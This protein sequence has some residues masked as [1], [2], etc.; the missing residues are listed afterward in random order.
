MRALLSVYDKTGIVEFAR[1]LHD[2]DVELV[3]SGGT[4]AKIAEAGIPVTDVAEF[5][6]YP[7]MLGHRVVTLHP[8]VHG[9]ILADPNDE[10]HQADIEQYGIQPFDLV[11]VN[12]YPFSSNPSVDMIDIGGPTMVRGA[13]KNFARVTVVVDPA[14]YNTIVV[15]VGIGQNNDK[16]L[17]SIGWRRSMARRAFAHTASYEAAIVQWFD[18]LDAAAERAAGEE[19]ELPESLHL[20]ATASELPLRYG[21]NPHQPGGLYLQPGSCWETLKIHGG[22]EMSYLNVYDANAA[23]RLVHSFC[24]GQPAIH[25]HLPT[26]VIVKHANPCGV[27]TGKDVREAYLR[28][29]A[30]DRESAFGG[31]VA[32]SKQVDV[33]TAREIVKIFTEVVVAPSYTK[34]AVAVLREKQ[35]LRILQMECPAGNELE[36]RMVDRGFLVQPPDRITQRE[37]H[38]RVVTDREPSLDEELDMEFA[39]R[40]AA[41]TTSNCIVLVKDQQ[42][43]G[44]GCGQQNRRDAGLIAAQKAAGRA[45]DG[46]CASDAFFPF[47]DGLDAAVKAGCTA[48]VQPGGSVR[49]DE[50]IAAANEAGI[51][52]VFTGTRHFKH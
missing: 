41:R 5:T 45:V 7:A 25:A 26:V 31:I 6:N 10:A 24:D 46:A 1:R 51:A 52:M 23:W 48:V 40:I 18:Q 49:D 27:A 15:M 34:A 16:P 2:L 19:P 12:L 11:V 50:V 32:F 20:A 30:C 8:L 3:S 14:D 4:A 29:L 28:A 9:A 35:N 38:W 22:K 36:V 43:V 21:E 13:A 39:W 47:R 33:R 17:G 44:I 37:L 42:S